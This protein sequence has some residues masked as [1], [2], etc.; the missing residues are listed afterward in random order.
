[1]EVIKNETIEE[2]QK[3]QLMSDFCEA[4]MEETD[5][6]KTKIQEGDSAL[7]ICTDGIKIA[8]RKCGNRRAVLNTLYSLMKN[9]DDFASLIMEAGMS[10]SHEML[11]RRVAEKIENSN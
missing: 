4:L 5:A 9:D 8:A 6:L 7:V 10:F 2:Q 11:G 3:P 1:M